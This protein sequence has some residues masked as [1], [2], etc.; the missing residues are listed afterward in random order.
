MGQRYGERSVSTVRSH[1]VI[2]ASP[3]EVW[4]VVADPRNLPRWNRRIQEV[5]GAP[6]NG[7]LEGSAYDTV[8]RLVGVSTTVHAEVVKVDPLRSSEVRLSGPL[9]AVVRTRLRPVGER[10]TVLEHVVTYRLKGGPV[11]ELLARAL[12]SLGAGAILRRGTRAQ[13]R[14]VEEG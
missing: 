4:E 6:K 3:E 11:G 13:K 9:D 10:R 12:R 1:E 14:Q 7:L 5:I 2:D 8:I